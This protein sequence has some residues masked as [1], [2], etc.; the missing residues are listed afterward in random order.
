MGTR[1]LFGFQYKG[2]R[3][4]FYNHYDSYPSGLGNQLL[5]EIKKAI[6]SGAFEAWLPLLQKMRVI[7]EGELPTKEAIEE[8]APFTDLSVSSQSTDDWYCLLRR[9]QGSLSGVLAAG[10]MQEMEIDYLFHEYVYIVNFD[11]EEF[12]AYATLWQKEVE[13]VSPTGEKTIETQNGLRKLGSWNFKN[14]P[15]S[16]QD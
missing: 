14:L 11:T 8:L 16:L 4:F 15:S 2:K 3:Y 12:E 10:Y 1:G 7:E 6:A 9:T 13:V 5:K